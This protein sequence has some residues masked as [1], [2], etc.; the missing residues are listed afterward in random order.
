MSKSNRFLQPTIDL[1]AQSTGQDGGSRGHRPSIENRRPVRTDAPFL[2]TGRI[3]DIT[4]NRST[5]S[6]SASNADKERKSR[7]KRTIKYPPSHPLT[8]IP[9]ATE[10]LADPNTFPTTVG[11]VEK[12]PPFADPLISTNAIRGPIEL[13]TGHSTKRLSALSS[14]DR[15]NVFSEPSLSHA[16]P[17]PSR[18]RAEEKLNAATRPAPAL[19]GRPREAV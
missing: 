17:H 3:Q 7:R 16:N 2:S 5:L 9:T 10:T 15:N 14:S 13:D 8:I 1:H 18:P 12:K 6:I 4:R 11:M 19:D